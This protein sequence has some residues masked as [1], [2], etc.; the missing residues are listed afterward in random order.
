MA[1]VLLR[2]LFSNDFEDFFPNLPLEG[3]NQLKEQLLLAVHNETSPNIRKK[4]CDVVAEMARNLIGNFIL[5]T[6]FF[7]IL[8]RKMVYWAVILKFVFVSWIVK[9]TMATICGQ[10]SWS[11]YSTVPIP[12]FQ[13]WKRA[14]FKCL[15]KKYCSF[16]FISL[17]SLTD[18]T[19]A[20]SGALV[21]CFRAVPGIFG[22][23][24]NQYLDVIKQ[25]LLQSLQD[26]G[27]MQVGQL[28]CQV[29]CVDG[30]ISG[31]WFWWDQQNY[32]NW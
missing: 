21:G 26:Q 13:R 20:I 29:G 15:G 14:V 32:L 4:V 5:L 23:V 24:Q 28:I 25:M 2:R 19:A 30:S 7:L 6:A 31:K 9:M 10:N 1:A 3:K 18:I 11:F 22:N 17:L 27:N 16:A 8:V 12:R